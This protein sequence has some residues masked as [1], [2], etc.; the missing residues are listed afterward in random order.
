M[1]NSSSSSTI[2]AVEVLVSS[3]LSLDS[4]FFNFSSFSFFS[5]IDFF[6]LSSS[7]KL[8]S[9][10]IISLTSISLLISLS[11]H[12]NIFLAVTGL[13]DKELTITYFPDSIL[14]AIAISPSLDNNSTPPIS[15]RYILIGSS[16]LS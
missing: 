8:V 5:L 15:R 11:S 16:L 12:S 10:S 6:N 2:S 14:F 4:F 13:S 9:R 1:L 7:K 3:P